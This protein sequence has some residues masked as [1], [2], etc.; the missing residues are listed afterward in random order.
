MICAFCGHSNEPGVRFCARCG[1]QQQE[2]QAPQQYPPQQYDTPVY[3]PPQEYQPQQYDTPV[4]SP[5]QEYPPQQY[6]SSVYPPQQQSG[7]QDYGQQQYGQQ[8]YGQQQYG[9]QDYGQ[10]QYGQQDYGRQQYQQSGKKGSPKHSSGGPLSNLPKKKILVIAAAVVVVIVAAVVV[11]SML[12]GSSSY[13]VKDSILMTED[14]GEV[15]IIANNNAKTT[16]DGELWY[17]QNSMDGSKAAV[18]VDYDSR[19]GGTLW[20]VTASDTTKVADDVYAFMLSDTGNGIA[21][22]TDYDNRD[23]TAFLYLYDTS[24]KS[25]A[26][27]TEDAFYNGYSQMPGV[28]ISPNGKT[29]AYVA[30]YDSR[31]DEFTSYIKIDGKAAEKLGDETFAVAISDGGSHQ[32]YVSFNRDGN[33]SLNVRSGR[34]ENRLASDMYR[35]ELMF[36][37]DYSEVIF[38]YDSRSYISKNGSERDRISGSP[39]NTIILPRGTQ[40]GYSYNSFFNISTSISVYG[41]RNLSDFV[42]RTGNGISYYDRALEANSI[43][44]TSSYTRAEISSDGKTL[45]YIN[46]SGRLSSIDPTNPSA[47]RSEIDRGVVSFASSTDG[48]SIYYVNTEYELFYASGGGTPKRISDDVYADSLTI[49]YNGNR[50]FFLVDY[51][52]SRGG[53]L[54]FSNNGGNRT[55][56]SGAEEVM[57]LL[58]TPTSVFYGNRDYQLY[59][60]SGDERFTMLHEFEDG[61]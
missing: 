6:D 44:G 14:N 38:E 19:T 27:A 15:I 35:L 1:A 4:Y 47:V 49:T 23:Q 52:Q 9:Q 45:Y 5:P 2:Q 18:V 40:Q 16:I 55:K 3:S 46:D 26:L 56:V 24:G 17:Y 53:D 7:Q 57:E 43:S 48:K 22:F 42:A 61:F 39:I 51:R 37:K 59:R 32:Y 12:G 10:Q 60:S 36:N 31:Y 21:Y 34:N 8:D 29:I 50:A 41:M 54:Y 13:Q 33:P 20:F 28:A 58:T 11:I 25:S 30:D